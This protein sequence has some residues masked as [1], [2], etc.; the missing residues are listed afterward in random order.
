LKP[1]VYIQIIA[2]CL[3]LILTSN[4]QCSASK[5]ST[6]WS[7]TYVHKDK[8][9]YG[10]FLC[11]EAL[12][13]V[14]PNAKLTET[15]NIFKY[16][17]AYLEEPLEDSTVLH[18]F[19]ADE[20]DFT[21]SEYKKLFTAISQGHNAVIIANELPYA[22]LQK[23]GLLQANNTQNF[24]ASG[25]DSSVLTS[26]KGI[27]YKK[28]Q[29]FSNQNIGNTMDTFLFKNGT[30]VNQY[31]YTAEK[32]NEEVETKSY[33][34][35]E[36][37]Y[38]GT[39]IDKSNPLEDNH[40]NKKIFSIKEIAWDKEGNAQGLMITL[41]KGHIL[42]HCSLDMFSNY[43]LIQQKNSKY[44]ENFFSFLPKTIQKI[45]YHEYLKRVVSNYDGDNETVKNPFGG[46]WKYKMWRN[47]ILLALGGI[48][49]YV[50]FN[51]KRRQRYIPEQEKI[52]NTSVDFAETI[53]QLY[54]NKQDHKNICEKMIAHFLEKVRTNYNIVTNKLDE[55][56]ATLL[57]KKSGADTIDTIHL[58]QQMYIIKT[59]QYISEEE[60]VVLYNK[61]QKFNNSTQNNG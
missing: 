28:L 19:S 29:T 56:F 14:F 17:K 59:H 55:D 12:M 54:Y 34:E 15:K 38:H 22:L 4:M 27:A 45:Q 8:L 50:L 31:F 61:I 49:L 32:F 37:D 13:H 20:I 39:N 58:V 1:I 18:F 47:A 53:G 35:N 42:L 6:N 16:K 33:N 7:K 24:F 43:F 40:L 48:L 36:E 21:I 5:S 23:F 10:T 51:H 9:P 44:A 46:L 26:K 57:A 3:L 60:L 30:P 52:V 2:L 41:G 25:M 11:H